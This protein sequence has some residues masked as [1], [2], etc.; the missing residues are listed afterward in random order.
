[1]KKLL[2][3]MMLLLF[4][5]GVSFSTPGNRDA[6]TGT[7]GENAT[8]LKFPVRV[9]KDGKPV[10]GLSKNDFL[11]KINGEDREIDKFFA[12]SRSL[13]Q[14]AGKM[15]RLFVLVINF[16]IA[17]KPVLDAFHSFLREIPA[18]DDKVM[19]W[20]PTRQ[21]YALTQI[22]DKEKLV[23][24]ADKVL[25][26][27]MHSYQ[28]ELFKAKENMMNLA[29]LVSLNFTNIQLFIDTYGRQFD[30]FK[31]HFLFPSLSEYD[32]LAAY[33]LSE[34]GEKWLIDFRS[35]DLLS[36]MPGYT[37]AKERIMEYFTTVKKNKKNKK[38][39]ANIMTAIE[40]LEK[41]MQLREG[42]SMEQVMHFLTGMNVS[43]NAIFFNKLPL[44]MPQ[45]ETGENEDKTG[46]TDKIAEYAAIITEMALRTG[47][48]LVPFTIEEATESGPGK[49]N[50]VDFGL[51]TGNTDIFYELVFSFNGE[52]EDKNIAVTTTAA[53]TRLYYKTIF[54][55]KEI[56][57]LVDLVGSTGI[58]ISGYE[59]TGRA[60]KFQ[61]HGF[62]LGK[63]K[64][65][66]DPRGLVKI[67]I[68]LIDDKNEVKYRTGR[69]LRADREAIDIALGLPGQFVGY[70]K[71]TIE[72]VDLLTGKS[73]TLDKYVKLN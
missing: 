6:N 50:G 22:G 27:D 29:R 37:R 65:S 3:M 8:L 18:A 58:A 35:G 12:K 34:P 45:K 33:L 16:Q 54:P 1:M 24:E 38:K 73:A 17:E 30:Y 60:L 41:K 42:W 56:E 14:P 15:G 53:G 72:T 48:V 11:L 4:F 28:Q 68:Q 2:M 26:P 40:E 21:I 5:L 69:T 71:L 19:L 46:K 49:G 25:E 36:F 10:S 63:Q 59:L 66:A 20:S 52:L 23:S 57:T 7:A 39:I 70:Y 13:S 64:G 47:G 62:Q 44:E 31:N 32:E 51:L 61:V 67:E 43:Y 9:F 55:S